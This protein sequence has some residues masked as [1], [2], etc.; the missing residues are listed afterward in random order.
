MLNEICAEVRNYFVLSGDVL[1]GDY[2]ISDGVIVPSVPLLEEQYF[3]IVGS[4]FNDGVHKS[5]DVL[6]DEPQF[7]GAV[8]LMRIPKDFLQLAD[9][10]A[11]WQAKHGGVDSAAM[12]PYNSESFGGYSYT[13]GTRASA[14]GG[15]SGSSVSWKDVFAQR[16]NVYRRI[17][18]I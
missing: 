15:S 4:V 2:T 14:S 18:T 12:S 6:T 9:E 3:R 17:R 16:L 8:W 10:I 13:K 7:H 5:G 1:V 11:Q